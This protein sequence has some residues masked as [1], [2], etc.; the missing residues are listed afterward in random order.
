MRS[1]QDQRSTGVQRRTPDRRCR[2]ACKE[3]RPW[4]PLSR[5]PIRG[6]ASFAP[7][8]TERA[9]RCERGVARNVAVQAHIKPRLHALIT[10]LDTLPGART[11]T[12]RRSVRREMAP[13]TAGWRRCYG[14]WPMRATWYQ[15]GCGDRVSF[16][17]GDDV[18]AGVGRPRLRN[19]ETHTDQAT[20]F[21][22]RALCR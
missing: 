8:C 15:S 2:A 10:A 4:R 9:W 12:P 17:L 3:H 5:L 16:R 21:L 19:E 22:E 13:A 1:A 7:P 18:P 20:R 11:P 6:R 14:G